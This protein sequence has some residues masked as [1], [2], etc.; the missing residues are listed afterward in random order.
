MCVGVRIEL[1]LKIKIKSES[2]ARQGPRRR[3]LWFSVA[4]SVFQ[5]AP[6][7]M[8]SCSLQLCLYVLAFDHRCNF[9][10]LSEEVELAGR[11]PGARQKA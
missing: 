9:R 3:Q 4:G 1:W 10:S 6:T 2:D 11:L 5:I 8:S 7:L